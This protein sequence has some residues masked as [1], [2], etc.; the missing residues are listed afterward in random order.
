MTNT[1]TETEVVYDVERS[2]DCKKDAW[3]SRGNVCSYKI[4]SNSVHVFKSCNT[5]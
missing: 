5:Q 1:V 3:S 2:S 4:H